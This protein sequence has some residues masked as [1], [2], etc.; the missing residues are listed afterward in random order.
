MNAELIVYVRNKNAAQKK[1]YCANCINCV[2]VKVPAEMIT[3]FILRV[4]CRK[5]HWSKKLGEEKLYKFFTVA[6]RTIETCGDYES[7][8]ELKAYLKELRKSL[9]LKDKIYTQESFLKP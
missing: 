7:M 8:G 1:V 6:R 4:R 5:K 9:H 2:L 3:K